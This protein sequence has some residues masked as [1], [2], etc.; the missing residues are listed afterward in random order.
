[1]KTIEPAG[2]VAAG[3]VDDRSTSVIQYVYR[4]AMVQARSWSW[5]AVAGK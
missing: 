5:K 3:R 4:E 1:V 2:D